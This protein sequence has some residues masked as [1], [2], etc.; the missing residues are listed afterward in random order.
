M[1]EI[2]SP[3]PEQKPDVQEPDSTLPNINITP[4]QRVK[5]R[6]FLIIGI[7]ILL[8]ICIVALGY[9]LMNKSKPAVK[10]PI[11]LQASQ[12]VTKEETLPTG[13]Q[14]IVYSFS[15]GADK[16]TSIY[17]YPVGGGERTESKKFSIPNHTFPSAVSGQQI[18][19]E[20]DAQDGSKD[21]LAIWYSSDNGKTFKQI[22]TGTDS[23]PYF[24]GGQI[25]SLIFSGDGKALAF[26]Y[27]VAN[28][29]TVKSIDL[30]TNNIIDLYTGKYRGV[31]LAAYDRASKQ[32]IYSEGCYNCDGG[33]N[34]TYYINNLTNAKVTTLLTTTSGSFQIAVRPDFKEMTVIHGSDDKFL[35]NGIPSNFTS[36]Y[37]ISL[38]SLPDGKETKITSVGEKP[39]SIAE[40]YPYVTVGYSTD[41]TTPFYAIDKK[42]YQIK[43]GKPNLTL[44]VNNP[45]IGI[46]YISDTSIIFSSGTYVSNSV[47]S[48]NPTDKTNKTL[49]KADLN[50]TIIGVTT[51]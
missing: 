10:N 47:V 28:K 21:P 38:Y 43:S 33:N 31:F 32:L 36:P 27:L 3:E 4:S 42:L 50:E 12:A 17:W 49:L 16:P 23:D 37:D 51:R 41:R 20:V 9:L 48:Y 15:E 6:K 1:D 2:S 7:I 39:K 8:I 46:Y 18:A 26:G 19:F 40:A 44:E 14:N 22:F 34:F 35:D 29:N 5:K 30:A 25:T 45:F 11:I 13:P 24:K